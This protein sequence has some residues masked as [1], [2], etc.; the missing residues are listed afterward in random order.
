MARAR[1]ARCH[2]AQGYFLSRPL[3]ATEFVEW[4]EAYDESRVAPPLPPEPII[5]P[6]LHVVEEREPA[7]PA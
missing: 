1:G 7:L 5:R 3:P 4:L 6:D 2:R